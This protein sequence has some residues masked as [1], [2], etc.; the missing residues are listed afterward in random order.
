[1]I[2]LCK[3]VLVSN[4]SDGAEKP[5]PKTSSNNT[6][7]A[8]PALVSLCPH[9]HCPFCRTLQLMATC[10]RAFRPRGGRAAQGAANLHHLHTYA[11]AAR[12]ASITTLQAPPWLDYAPTCP[13]Q[14]RAAP[15]QPKQGNCALSLPALP[16][17]YKHTHRGSMH[18][19]EEMSSV[20]RT[21]QQRDERQAV[22]LQEPCRRLVRHTCR[23]NTPQS[24]PQPG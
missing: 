5:D 12:P 8:S 11:T 14:P 21:A 10:I 23:N 20:N 15:V 19:L 3:Q 24:H 6:Q 2:G 13:W 16:V 1:M 18:T 22:T 7:A 9:K 4:T 17:T